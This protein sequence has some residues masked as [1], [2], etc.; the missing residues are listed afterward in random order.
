MNFVLKDAIIFD[1]IT[2]YVERGVDKSQIFDYLKEMYSD[3][4]GTFK[5][6]P[7]NE[8]ARIDDFLHYEDVDNDDMSENESNDDDDNINNR[9]C[10]IVNDAPL[11]SSFKDTVKGNYEY[12][13]KQGKSITT[14]NG[15]TSKV[16]GI[17]GY[18]S[19]APLS[20][21]IHYIGTNTNGYG[22]DFGGGFGYSVLL[23]A[24]CSK[25]KF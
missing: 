20:I 2:P 24:A 14:N 5:Y 19:V 15:L 22:I 10:V 3:I 7:N 11:S 13:V 1:Q 21:L 23:Y 18:L 17:N 9:V 12:I 16:L 4:E 6:V 25:F 8:N